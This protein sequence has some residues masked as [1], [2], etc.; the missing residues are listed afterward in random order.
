[1]IRALRRF[2]LQSEE[3][4]KETLAQ[5]LR[6]VVAE[7]RPSA[8]TRELELQDLLAARECT[9]ERFLPARFKKC[10][11]RRST[12]AS[13]SALPSAPSRQ[14]SCPFRQMLV[15]SAHED[16]LHG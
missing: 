5:I 2:E 15:K 12:P 13:P 16:V 8:Q 14:N 3:D 9:D 6:R 10:R 11:A 1:L 4:K 7:F